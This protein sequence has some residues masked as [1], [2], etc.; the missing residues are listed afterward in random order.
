MDDAATLLKRAM[1]G[2]AA[3]EALAKRDGTI[4]PDVSAWARAHF[5]ELLAAESAL[6][7]ARVALGADGGGGHAKPATEAAPKLFLQSLEA[8][9]AAESDSIAVS[10]GEL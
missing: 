2:I 7:R 1:Q 8:V 6:S 3:L 5:R 10:L 4:G 9:S